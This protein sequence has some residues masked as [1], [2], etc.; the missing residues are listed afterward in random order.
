MFGLSNQE[1]PI[2]CNHIES[3][4]SNMNDMKYDKFY[5]GT[6]LQP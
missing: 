2:I 5:R 4:Y 1:N 3:G 6:T